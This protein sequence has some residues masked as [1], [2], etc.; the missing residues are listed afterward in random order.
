MPSEPGVGATSGRL[1]GAAPSTRRAG[2][3][4]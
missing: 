1:A 4:R 3:R 2:S